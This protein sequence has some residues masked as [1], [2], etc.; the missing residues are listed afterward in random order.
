MNAENLAT[1]QRLPVQPVAP[2]ENQVGP[3]S[4]SPPEMASGTPMGTGLLGAVWGCS[5][6]VERAQGSSCGQ[7]YGRRMTWVGVTCG[8]RLSR[9]I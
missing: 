1:H 2:C 5:C 9:G 7:R 8:D 4:L 3:I 6:L